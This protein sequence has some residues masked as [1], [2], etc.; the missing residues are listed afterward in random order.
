M[1]TY[2]FVGSSG[3]TEISIRNGVISIE[4]PRTIVNESARVDL[5]QW[6]VTPGFTV[7]GD[8]KKLLT[9]AVGPKLV[10]LGVPLPIQNPTMSIYKYRWDGNPPDLAVTIDDWKADSNNVAEILT[11]MSSAGAFPLEPTETFQRRPFMTNDTSSTAAL[12]SLDVGIYT[13]Q[14]SSADDWL[15]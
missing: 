10:D 3:L 5:G 7:V 2:A 1:G 8:Q 15:G 4:S 9:Q 13:V 11:A 6:D 14:V 12:V